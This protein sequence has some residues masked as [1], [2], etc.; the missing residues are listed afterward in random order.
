[1][2]GFDD[3][4]TAEFVRPALTTV[5]LPKAEL[6]RRSWEILHDQL[7]DRA[8]TTSVRLEPTLVVRESTGPAALRAV[9]G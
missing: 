9:N 2:V 1:V 3:I 8:A 6:G 7:A 4:A 5:R